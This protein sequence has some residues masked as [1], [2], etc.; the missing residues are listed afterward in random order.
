MLI[1][2]NNQEPSVVQNETILGLAKLD[3]F[4][5]VAL[6]A[7]IVFSALSVSFVSQKNRHL[8]SQLELSRKDSSQ[9][10]SRWTRLLLERSTLGS[11]ARIE[12]FARNKLQLKSATPQDTVIIE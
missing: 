3:F 4:I 9:L 10:H 5:A 6:V 12:D 2:S 7:A 1:R 8:F 11:N